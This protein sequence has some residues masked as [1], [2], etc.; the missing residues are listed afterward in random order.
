MSNKV[1]ERITRIRFDNDQFERG[2][3]TSMQSLDRLKN[4]LESTES[5]EAFTGIQKAADKT[6]FSGLE[7]AISSVGDKFSYLRMIAINVLS[8][9]ASKAISTGVSLVKNLSTDNIAAGWEKYDQEVQA[10]QTIMVTLDDT[11]IE[12]VEDHLKKVGWY[13][14]E[15]SYSYTEM[16]GAMSKLISSG[17]NLEDATNAVIGISN[18]AAAAG[19]S[20]KK[21]QQAFYNFSQAFGSGYMQLLDWRSIEYLNMG[22]PEFKKNIIRTAVEMGKIV[23]LGND[24]YVAASKY[25]QKNW[26]KSVFNVFSMRDSLSDKWFD[27]DVM[28]KVLGSYTNFTN[29]VYELQTAEDSEYDTAS[30]VIKALKEQGEN[31]DEYSAKAF[32]AGQ[33]AK[34]FAEAIGSVKDAVSTKWK[35]TFKALFGNYE[36]AK[37]LWTDLANDL[38][39]LFAASGDVRNEILA[40]WNDPLSFMVPDERVR[41]AYKFPE[42]Q[43]GRDILVKGLWNI[44]DSIVNVVNLIKAAWR[45]V[46][47]EITAKKLYEL[48][49]KFRDITARLKTSTEDLSGLKIFLVGVFSAFKKVLGFGKS[50]FNL[51][52]KFWPIIEKLWTLTVKVANALLDFGKSIA[53]FISQNVNLDPV[54]NL[55]TTGIESV[56]DWLDTLNNKDI[57][58]PA[59]QTIIDTSGKLLEKLDPVKKTLE[60]VFTYL[61]NTVIK[62]ESAD[63]VWNLSDSIVSF[64]ENATS[65]GA[66]VG[67]ALGNLLEV[68]IE[69]L[70]FASTLL[71]K[72]MEIVGKVINWVREQVEGLSIG[73]LLKEFIL[74]G[75]GKFIISLAHMVLSVFKI[76]AS[77]G[78]ILSS[79]SGLIRSFARKNTGELIESIA[80]SI[81]LIAGSLFLVSKIDK[82]QLSSAVGILAM[83]ITSIATMFLITRMV[84]GYYE[85]ASK[86]SKRIQLKNFGFVGLGIAVLSMTLA[87]RSIANL[88]TKDNITPGRLAVITVL[89]VGL[90]AAL[91]AISIAITRLSGKNRLGLAAFYP[92]SLALAI[93]LMVRAF[94]MIDEMEIKHVGK[95]VLVVLGVLGTLF[96]AGLA[97][98][99]FSAGAG[100]GVIMFALTFS[101]MARNFEKIEKMSFELNNRTGPI[102]I[103]ITAILGVFVLYSA[104]L[105]KIAGPEF[106]GTAK[107]LGAISGILLLS[108]SFIAIASAFRILNRVGLGTILVG[109]L[110]ISAI[111]GV[112]IGLVATAGKARIGTFS[113]IAALSILTVGLSILLGAISVLAKAP[114]GGSLAAALELSLIVG[115]LAGLTFAAGKANKRSFAALLSIAAITGGLTLL[116]LALKALSKEDPKK[117]YASVSVLGIAMAE[118]LGMYFIITKIS[119]PALSAIPT[120][121]TITLTAGLLGGALVLFSALMDDAMKSIQVAAAIGIFAITLSASL[122]IIDKIN[123]ETRF[124]NIIPL[125]ISMGLLGTVLGGILNLFSLFGDTDSLIKIATSIGI[126]ALALSGAIRI[127]GTMPKMSTADVGNQ[128]L[129]FGGIIVILAGVITTMSLLLND[130]NLG[131]IQKYGWQLLAV[132]GVITALTVLFGVLGKVID[133]NAALQG[134][135]ALAIVSGGILLIGILLYDIVSIIE[136]A[137]EATGQNLVEKLQ[138]VGDILWEIGSLISKLVGGAL[139]GGLSDVGE[140]LT[141]FSEKVGPFIDFISSIPEGFGEKITDFAKGFAVFTNKGFWYGFKDIFQKGDLFTNT[142]NIFK[143]A[144]EP[145]ADMVTAFSGIENVSSA[146]DVLGFIKQLGPAMTA[147]NK[148]QINRLKKDVYPAM[149]DLGPNVESFGNYLLNID[150][151]SIQRLDWLTQMLEGLGIAAGSFYNEYGGL[152]QLAEIGTEIE[153]LGSGVN[154]FVESSGTVTEASIIKADLVKQMVEKLLEINS[155]IDKNRG[156]AAW[157]QGWTDLGKFGRELGSFVSNGLSQFFLAMDLLTIEYLKSTTEKVPYVTDSLKQIISLGSLIGN[158]KGLWPT[159]SGKTD[160]S[161]FGKQIGFLADGAVNFAAKMAF[162]QSDVENLQTTTNGVVGAIRSLAELKDFDISRKFV[163]EMESLANSATTAFQAAFTDDETK[164]ATYTAVVKMLAYIQSAAL[165]LSEN[166]EY[167]KSLLNPV[168]EALSAVIS[169]QFDNL[170]KDYSKLADNIASGYVNGLEESIPKIEKA[171]SKLNKTIDKANTMFWEVESPS[172]RTFRL[173]NYIGQG[174]AKGILASKDT[175]SEAYNELN[176][177]L[178]DESENDVLSTVDDIYN[179]IASTIS[180]AADNIFDSNGTILDNIKSF[181]SNLKSGIFTSDNE[182]FNWIRDKFSEFIGEYFGYSGTFDGTDW[183]KLV[184]ESGGNPFLVNG[185]EDY[186]TQLETEFQNWMSKSYDLNIT[187]VFTD[188]NGKSIDPTDWQSY[189]GSGSGGTLGGTVAGYT[190]ED[191]RNLTLEIY[192]LEDA[193]YSLKEAMKDQQV[194]HSGELTIHYSN[195][196]DFVDR[197]QTAI[198]GEIRREIRS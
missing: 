44:Y 117:M 48:T 160:F 4:K 62:K 12:E 175:V 92:L 85:K 9:I 97:I 77:F 46:F 41:S 51:A 153:L 134:I 161:E 188:E 112:M 32:I 130:S 159:L 156:A 126:A 69:F 162:T 19:V 64:G 110:I 21:A 195:E 2:V 105:K 113:S 132:V 182:G 57:S 187:P 84:D 119:S 145:L 34:T 80:K 165:I 58:I 13:A 146:T 111:L 141:E 71:G 137:Y 86:N 154:S 16:V 56:C 10:V 36:E 172:K 147:L 128:L 43:A 109:G 185:E 140:E 53:D 124:K 139:V 45:E 101:I 3:A 72:V 125:I 167:I 136:L 106:G 35:D 14:D 26:E 100:L 17:V 55:I 99:K 193:L 29:K 171:T 133:A 50:L 47:P 155:S 1:D 142:I 23:D 180:N 191:V 6:D 5:V 27:K 184:L 121:I 127:L 37:V 102:I 33:E 198:I 60:D 42:L 192:H 78:Q 135:K 15:T 52:K 169:N 138:E 190:A 108:L 40:Q 76:V 144:A 103:A 39:D 28:N 176:E 66:Y 90:A 65:I 183:Q 114:I 123:P 178:G 98:R 131:W 129:L 20:T 73:E 95:I 168:F 120:I 94:K 196:S 38:Y 115:T 164:T 173:G 93:T 70:K 54:L 68:I 7:K 194:T 59:F 104:L 158:N 170:G 61:W 31:L 107:M 157:F 143:N 82:S 81:L 181:F 163:T 8:D 79:V 83:I 11:T 197:V 166:T 49:K 96:L 18:A 179:G 122:L 89:V 67:I 118:L 186:F 75:I 24:M 22:T 116:I 151:N 63:D 177:E 87:I 30:E 149:K 25:G 91:E 74:I 88:L 152:Y 150:E 189:L 148:S 174:M